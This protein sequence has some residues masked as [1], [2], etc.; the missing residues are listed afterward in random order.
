MADC[1]E[2][3]ASKEQFGCALKPRGKLASFCLSPYCLA[4]KILLHAKRALYTC[5]NE[6]TP[7]A[8]VTKSFQKQEVS[9]KIHFFTSQIQY[10]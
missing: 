10:F 2:K 3:I 5:I 9:E 6:G 4:F 7:V 1:L 8:P